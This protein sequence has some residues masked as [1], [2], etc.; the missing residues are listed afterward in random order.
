MASILNA[1][2]LS[3]AA[4]TGGFLTGFV[5]LVFWLREDPHPEPR[6]IL[7]LTFIAG[8]AAVPLSLVLEE[9]VYT[10]GLGAGLWAPGRPTFLLLVLWAVIE[11]GFKFGAAWWAAL[12]RPYFDEPI[13]AP[14]YLITAALGFA[15]L[16]NAF[17]LFNVF[18]QEFAN[19]FVTANLR[20]IGATLLHIITASIVGFSIAYSFFH[21]ENRARNIAGGLFL[22]VAL[23]A[24]FNFFILKGGGTNLLSVFSVVW[25]GIIV[26]ILSFEKIKKIIY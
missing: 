16:E 9:M 10:T 6:R 19:G 1:P 26:V 15:A 12:R 5:W 7:M 18:S 23:H 8:A 20:F 17:M 25:L 14:I 11:E 22:A 24:L 4:I 21:T 3:V 13:D 2:F